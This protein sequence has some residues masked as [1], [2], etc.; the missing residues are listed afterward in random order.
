[1]SDDG[2]PPPTKGTELIGPFV[3]REPYRLVVDGCLV[4]HVEFFKE[5]AGT[6]EVLIDG[7]LAVL[8][9]T[10]A[11]IQKWGYVLANAMAIASGLSHFGPEA[12]PKPFASRMIGIT[13]VCLEGDPV[14]RPKLELVPSGPSGGD[15][16]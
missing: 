7:R 3:A 13:G 12:K 9:L 16:P 4:P 2:L 1:M 8:E 11:E 10:E 14:P 15:L 6:Y 5:P